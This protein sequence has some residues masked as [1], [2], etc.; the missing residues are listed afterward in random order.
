MPIPQ[1]WSAFF[2]LTLLLLGIDSQFGTLEGF[3]APFY[4]EKLVRMRKEIFTGNNS[5]V[6]SWL[7]FWKGENLQMFGLSNWFKKI[8]GEQND[9][10]FMKKRYANAA[11]QYA[12]H[13]RIKVYTFRFFHPQPWYP[14]KNIDNTMTWEVCGDVFLP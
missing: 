14:Q 7:I 2:F 8:D 9:R 5:T 3:I 13:F 6:K 12:C 1:L 10:V 4:D 11:K